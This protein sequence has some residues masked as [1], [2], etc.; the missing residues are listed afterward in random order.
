MW[1]L[2]TILHS[3]IHLERLLTNGIALP[4]APALPEAGTIQHVSFFMTLVKCVVHIISDVVDNALIYLGN[5][6][7]GRE[8]FLSF[9]NEI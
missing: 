5:S 2:L 6:G 9:T 1:N 7:I 3:Q 4:S 8:L